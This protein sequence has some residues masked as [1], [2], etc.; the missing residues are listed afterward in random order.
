MG[1]WF[2]QCRLP[3]LELAYT[4][5]SV[6]GGTKRGIIVQAQVDYPV[7]YWLSPTS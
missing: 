1:W 6:K 3:L 7:F 4:I 5:S 2:A